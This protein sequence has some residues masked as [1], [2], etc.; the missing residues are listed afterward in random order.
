MTLKMHKSIFLAEDDD[1]DCSIFQ[2]ALNDVKVETRL[3]ITND[4][5]ELL[6]Y[7]DETVPPPPYV[8]FLDLNMPR[9]NGIDSLKEI[10]QTHK[11]K[12]IP[13]V[14]LSTSSNSEMI[15][16]TYS[17]GANYYICKPTSYRTLSKL[18]EKVL[19][20]DPSSLQQQPS[21]NEFVL[22]A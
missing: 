8:I 3:T 11:L 22:V 5:V 4:G 9:K 6:T 2:D 20:L 7:L 18:I 12:D 17:L 10:R 13:V 16:R 15:D 14:I 19:S 1:D 21:R